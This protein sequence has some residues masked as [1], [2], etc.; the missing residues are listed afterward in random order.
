MGDFGEGFGSEQ[1]LSDDFVSLGDLS[2][3]VEDADVD[4][5]LAFAQDYSNE[6]EDF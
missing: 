4:E 2:D 5:N 3:L 1:E 6:D